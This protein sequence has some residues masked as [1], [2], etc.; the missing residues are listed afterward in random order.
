MIRLIFTIVFAIALTVSNLSA[1]EGPFVPCAGCEELDEVPYPEPG[2]W[3]NPD[4][5]GS[6]FNLEFQNGHMAGF[7]YTYDA[8]GNPQWYLLNQALVRSETE[9]VMWEVEVQPEHYTGGNCPTC[10]YQ[11]PGSPEYLDAIRIEFLQRAYAR[12]T[13]SNGSVQYLVPI[14]YGSS[15]NAYFEEIT[16][17][18]LPNLEPGPFVTLWSLNF[19]Q[20]HENEHS[21]WMWTA[22]VVMITPASWYSNAEGNQVIRYRVRFPVPPPEV[23][24]PFGDIVCGEALPDGELGCILTASGHNLTEFHMPIA[25]FTDS[26]L[27]GE[28]VE[29]HTVEGF[30]LRYD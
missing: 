3:Y 18:V 27:F 10:D 11:A 22:M 13:L 30:R 17:Y 16:P 4:Q 21:P 14:Q 24:A 8:E 7:H 15:G 25:N 28:S 6:G 1:Q 20:F 9:G 19:K 23:S 29:G 26:R 2:L 5:S 12:L